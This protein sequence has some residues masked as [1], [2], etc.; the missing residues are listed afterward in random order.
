MHVSELITALASDLP[1]VPRRPRLG[2][3]LVVLTALASLFSLGAILLLLSR[4]PHLAHGP[5]ATI[6]FTA[7]AGAIL[8]AGAFSAALQ[9]CHPESRAG[10]LWLLLPAA[11]LL[12][13]LGLELSQAPRSSWP[14]RFWG[15]NPLACFLCITALSLP[16]LAAVLLA[17]REGAP[18]QPRLCGA[19]AG[20]LSSGIAAALYTLHCPENSLLFIA[21]WHVLAVLAVTL[22]GALA[23]ERILRW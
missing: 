8:A 20:L 2:V 1:T 22:V 11:I 23:A 3:K 16:I 17:L 4:S 18:A 21:F 7:F 14:A 15:G 6:V 5:S 13:G 9:L 19:A 10:F 12:T